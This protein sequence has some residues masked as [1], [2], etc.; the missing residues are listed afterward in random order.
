MVG[1]DPSEV[2]RSTQRSVTDGLRRTRELYGAWVVRL[3]LDVARRGRTRRGEARL[4]AEIVGR[5]YS[6]KRKRDYDCVE[7]LK[8]YSRCRYRT[9]RK[10]ERKR[11]QR[12]GRR[13]SLYIH[14]DPCTA[15]HLICQA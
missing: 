12:R 11:K 14:R 6:G 2:D 5:Y 1:G 8:I 4:W 3:R 9:L 7:R 10:E 13:P 15:A